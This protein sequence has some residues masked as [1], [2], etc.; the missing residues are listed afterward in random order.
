MLIFDIQ[1][2]LLVL[3]ALSVHSYMKVVMGT[4]ATMIDLLDLVPDISR[5]VD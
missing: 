1:L 3:L 5:S 2:T 4:E